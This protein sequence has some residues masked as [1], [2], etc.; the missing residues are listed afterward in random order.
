MHLE[1]AHRVLVVGRDEHHGHVALEELQHL[2][3]R[4]PR[5]L[6]VEKQQVGV[7]LGRGPDRLEPV[8]ALRHDL[9]FRVRREVLAQERPGRLLVVDD[10]DT[11]R[12]G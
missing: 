3:P 7:E 4:E 6:D 2:E 9:D 5:H 8:G 10:R 12:A 1:G 11:Q